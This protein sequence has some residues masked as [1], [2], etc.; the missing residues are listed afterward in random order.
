MK[1]RQIFISIISTLLAFKAQANQINIHESITL[2]SVIVTT[3][4]EKND[5]YN[6]K[7]S[8]SVMRTNTA[9][10]DTPQS[11]AVVT[12][13]QIRDQNITK[14][15]EA[16]RYT[17]GVSL[18]QGENNRDQVVIRGNSTSADFFID[19]AR[20]DVQYFRDFYNMDRIEILKGP[21]A[22]AFGRGGSGGLINR[23][24]K[25]AD[26]SRV[27]EVVVSGGSYGNRRVQADVGDKVNDI[28]AVR[29][30]GMYEQSGTFRQHG[31][32]ERYGINPTVTFKLGKDTRLLAGY[33]YFH[34]ARFNDR[35]IPSQNGLP[36]KTDPKT[37]FGNPNENHADVTVNSGY[38]TLEHNFTP[39]LKLKNYTRYTE[40]DKFY[41][42]AYAGSPVD[43]AGNLTLA[44]YNNALK[45][46]TLTNQT[47][48]TKKF[49]T[50]SLEHT[51]LLGMEITRQDSEAF[52]NTGFFD[53]ATTTVKVPAVNPVSF[54]PITYR[55]NATDADNHSEV[56]VYAGYLQD[57]IDINKYLQVTG[58]LRFDS[59]KLDYH[60]NRNGQDL[61]RTDNMISPRAGIVVKPIK[62]VSIYGNYNVSFL[63]SSGDQFS[64][65]TVQTAAF[66]PE[67]LD[68][69]EIGVKWDI[70]PSLNVS[71]AIY[72]LNRTNT[73]AVDPTNPNNIILTGKT[74][75]RGVELGATGKITDK[76]QIIAAYAYQDAIV[77][78]SIASG[79]TPISAGNTVALV[80]NNMASLWN[81][82]DFTP[83]FAAAV[84][85]INQSAQ[86]A[87]V[88]N[89]VKLKGFTRFDA[90]VYCTI[91]PSYR[92]QLNVENLLDREYFSTADGNNNLQPGSP[93]AFKVSVTAKF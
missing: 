72:E 73:K 1:K 43:A 26:G 9:L 46:D 14:M 90:A 71:A 15:G 80:P 30:N 63:P 45:R 51:A 78:N 70:N 54:A 8:L 86:Y 11:V 92:I 53:N 61:S 93:Q 91:N 34:D 10:L 62:D 37:F 28:V 60:N 47:D 58:G 59:F 6:S 89:T 20:D 66:K 36:Y 16:I 4:S 87:N 50:G 67:S 44:A 56:R 12:Q 49:T 40:N 81:K 31:D 39:T 77:K 38:A 84:G 74:R 3:Q 55:Q 25:T 7:S 64:A 32:L 18:H 42:N 79:T 41:K 82:Y 68:N 29:L 76:W 17:P 52:R 5:G 85:V 24:S 19:G 48:L 13:D 35:G 2:P 75:T 83:E 27:R 88:D 22:L 57:Q 33:E 69:K 65:L 21:N 23:I